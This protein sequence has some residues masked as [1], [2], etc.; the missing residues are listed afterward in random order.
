[1]R[2]NLVKREPVVNSIRIALTIAF[3]STGLNSNAAAVVLEANIYDPKEVYL[4]RE[5]IWVEYLIYNVSQDTVWIEKLHQVGARTVS[6]NV[7]NEKTGK[8]ITK[9]HPQIHR[10]FLGKASCT[11]ISPG[12]TLRG[13]YDLTTWYGGQLEAGTFRIGSMIY[14]SIFAPDRPPIWKGKLEASIDFV[15]NVKEPEGEEK[16]ALTMFLEEEK[17]ALR[18]FLEARNTRGHRESMLL[19][20]KVVEL[21]PHSVYA[22]KAQ[23]M[24]IYCTRRLSSSQ[25]ASEERIQ[26][27]TEK[28]ITLYPDSPYALDYVHGDRIYLQR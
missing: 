23:D 9:S 6:F 11:N 8:R 15:I 17:K 24:M 19:Y 1:M 20:S 27:E 4:V 2:E 26:E 10:R 3:L 21:F 12:D 16:E 14:R 25:K 18:M 22:A 7:V 28:L 5:P 13:F